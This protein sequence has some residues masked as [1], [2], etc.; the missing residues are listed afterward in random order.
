MIEFDGFDWD[1][2]NRHK[3]WRKHSVQPKEAE[4]IFFNEP[5][6]IFDDVK[7]SE[8]EKRYLAHGVSKKSRKLTVVFTLRDEKVRIISARPMN[9]K[10]RDYY[11]RH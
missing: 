11:D 6:I 2:G 8:S 9:K 3:S 7:H 10:D 4:E 1:K 5:L